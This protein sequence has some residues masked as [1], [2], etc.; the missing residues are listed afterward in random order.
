MQAG[1][2]PRIASVRAFFLGYHSQILD[3]IALPAKM[4]KSAVE[5]PGELDENPDRKG[6]QVWFRPVD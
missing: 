2:A 4:A 1:V 6:R 5:E 3:S